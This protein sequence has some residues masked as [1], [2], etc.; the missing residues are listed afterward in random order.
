MVEYTAEEHNTW[1]Q[2][3]TMLKQLRPTHTCREY[4]VNVRRM[5]EAGVISAD[6]IPQ[7]RDLNAYI[8]SLPTHSNRTFRA[9][10]IRVATVW[11]IAFG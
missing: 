11:G 5:E 10:R 9:Y 8:Q 7:I 2:A 6:K 3:Y 4:Q 1:K